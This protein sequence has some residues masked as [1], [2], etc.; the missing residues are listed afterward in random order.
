LLSGLLDFVGLI[1]MSLR[2]YFGLSS[3]SSFQFLLQVFGEFLAY[4][5]GFGS[6]YPF[7]EGSQSADHTYIRFIGHRYLIW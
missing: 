3:R 7:P 4:R 2:L 6:H 5:P 1:T